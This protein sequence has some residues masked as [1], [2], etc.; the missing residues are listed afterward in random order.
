MMRAMKKYEISRK[1]LSKKVIQSIPMTRNTIKSRVIKISEDLEDQMLQD[2]KAS[3]V[4]HA[5]Q[6][7]SST[8]VDNREQLA[9]F[10]RWVTSFYYLVSIFILK[11]KN[12]FFRY[13]A[14]GKVKE[15]MLFL[16]EIELNA[17]A[18]ATMQ[19]IDGYYTKNELPMS[20]TTHKTA[21]GCPV[22]MGRKTGVF[23]QSMI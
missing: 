7:D 4:G 10:V 5:F 15:E 17:T 21:D 16:K 18:D 20:D 1:N 9:A 19:T 2:L 12:Y 3:P 8:D 6:A 14:C 13:E 23:T 11:L 22:M